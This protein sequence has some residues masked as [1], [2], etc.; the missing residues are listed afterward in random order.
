ML[1]GKLNPK[2]AGEREQSYV[3]WSRRREHRSWETFVLEARGRTYQN[4]RNP[5]RVGLFREV[6]PDGE[7]RGTDNVKRADD[8]G[9]AV[10]D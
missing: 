7:Q 8:V 6:V 9:G 4:S 10:V 1:G 5:V 3:P 2:R